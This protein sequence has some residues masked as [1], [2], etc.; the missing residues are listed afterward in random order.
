MHKMQRGAAANHATAPRLSSPLSRRACPEPAAKGRG[1]QGVRTS[2]RLRCLPTTG[3]WLALGFER[4]EDVAGAAP[5]A[6]Q[7]GIIAEPVA[8]HSIQRAH[9][10]LDLGRH[11]V[12]IGAGTHMTAPALARSLRGNRPTRPRLYC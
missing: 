8:H 6:H 12:E 2:R 5:R 7:L 9:L 11:R 10:L 1:G 4:A 3:L